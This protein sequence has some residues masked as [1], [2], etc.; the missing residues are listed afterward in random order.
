MG[1]VSLFTLKKNKRFSHQNLIQ[2]NYSSDNLSVLIEIT[3]EREE[4]KA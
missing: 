1:G 4:T 3:W 2:K